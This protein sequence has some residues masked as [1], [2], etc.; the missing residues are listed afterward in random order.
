[1]ILQ[2]LPDATP[3]RFSSNLYERLCRLELLLK[4]V[5]HQV[6]A[7]ICSALPRLSAPTGLVLKYAAVAKPRSSRGNYTIMHN[8]IIQVSV[9]NR[10]T[11]GQK[12]SVPDRRIRRGMDLRGPFFLDSF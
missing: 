1:M 3:L 10:T 11:N 2:R 7:A 8:H 4:E 9:V 6:I 5:Q 12:V